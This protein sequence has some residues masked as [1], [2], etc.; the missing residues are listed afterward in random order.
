MEWGLWMPH[1][2]PGWDEGR[3]TREFLSVRGHVS[4]VKT[5]LLTSINPSQAIHSGTQHQM[6]HP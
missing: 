5:E 4:P 3:R 2:T 6:P 1:V